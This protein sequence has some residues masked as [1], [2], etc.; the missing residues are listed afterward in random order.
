MVRVLLDGHDGPRDLERLVG[1]AAT[2]GHEQ[3]VAVLLD[4]GADRGAASARPAVDL[5]AVRALRRTAWL[6]TLRIGE[7]GATASRFGGRPWLAEGEPWPLDERGRPLTFLLQVH[8]EK[9]PP[10]FAPHGGPGLLQLFFDLG[11]QPSEPFSPGQLVRVVDPASWRGGKA[12]TP[13]GA[14]LLPARCIRGWRPVHD[15]P[16]GEAGDEPRHRYR[17]AVP[18]RVVGD[19]LGANVCKDKLG[20]WASWLDGPRYP[21]AAGGPSPGHAARSA[22]EG[23][24]GPVVLDRLV[25]QIVSDGALPVRFGDRGR[26]YVLQSSV[27]PARLAFLWQT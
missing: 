17:V 25:F 18:E 11:A 1:L 2:W 8:L 22:R 10:A 12:R 5:R 20:G 19:V 3:V 26:G 7:G 9:I 23:T 27:D 21:S 16:V 24:A 14:M 6:P 13:R 15:A 4:A